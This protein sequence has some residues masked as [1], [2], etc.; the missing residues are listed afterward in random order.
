MQSIHT[1]IQQLAAASARGEDNSTLLAMVQELST[2]LQAVQSIVHEKIAM[3]GEA[4]V[5]TAVAVKNSQVLPKPSVL[6]VPKPP[7]VVAVEETETHSVVEEMPAIT[8]EAFEPTPVIVEPTL[9]QSV[10]EVMPPDEVEPLPVAIKMEEPETVHA[11]PA[12]ASIADP[13]V[14]AALQHMDELHAAYVPP[15][16][17]AAADEVL[18]LPLTDEM[19]E[20][21]EAIE[22][23][24]LQPLPESFEQMPTPREV[25]EEDE[26]REP[27]ELNEKLAHRTKV[28]N[29][30]FAQPEPVLAEKIVP[31][32]IA[33]IRKAISIL[34]KYQFIQSLFRGDEQMFERSVK[35]LNGFEIL[36]E[37]QYWMQRELVI[38]LG[39][40]EE[41]E[42]VQQFVSLVKRR[43]A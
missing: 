9:S 15:V 18:E 2:K 8:A 4:D 11:A 17:A 32:K 35:T 14:K 34:E 40:N 24:K 30:L 12:Y 3:N 6:Y 42:L 21:A 39:W 16:T 31:G 41:D 13:M 29:E 33:D 43:F 25:A 27:K 23:A 5:V 19:I 20:E 7:A 1:L 28:L 26:R 10:I 38:K 36:P 22:M 37:A